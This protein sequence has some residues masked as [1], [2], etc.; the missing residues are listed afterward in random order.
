MSYQEQQQQFTQKQKLVTE[1]G[2]GVSQQLLYPHFVGIGLFC[3]FAFPVLGFTMELLW[4]Y[5]GIF[6]AILVACLIVVMGAGVL[7]IL[8]TMYQGLSIKNSLSANANLSRNLIRNEQVS[9]YV[10][11]DGTVRNLTAEIEQVRHSGEPKDEPYTPVEE[12][13]YYNQVNYWYEKGLSP[14]QICNKLFLKKDIVQQILE[15][16]QEQQTVERKV[17]K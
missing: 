3:L 12:P 2:P 17:L 6:G 11:P 4:L 14:E 1:G 16:M 13:N 8:V 9:L 10:L 7:Y 15:Q 5:A